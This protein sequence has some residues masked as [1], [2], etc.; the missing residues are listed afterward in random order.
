[1]A[2]Q[3]KE[4]RKAP[5][6]LAGGFFAWFRETSW[7]ERAEFNAKNGGAMNPFKSSWKIPATVE[8]VFAA[9]WSG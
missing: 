3:S 1:M 2:T 6:Q 5:G 4:A 7:S 9:A 8:Q